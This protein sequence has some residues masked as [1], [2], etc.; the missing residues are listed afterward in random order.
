MIRGYKNFL[1][2]IILENLHPELHDVINKSSTKYSRL[3]KQTELVKKIQDLNARGEKT[4]LEGNMPKGSSRAYLQHAEPHDIEV[5]GKKRKM[6]IG[7]KVAIKADL[8]KHHDD[9]DESLGQMQNRIENSDYH[10]NQHHRILTHVE[11]NKYTDNSE[12]GIFP[13]LVDHD[14]EKHNWSKVAHTS[15]ITKGEFKKR[16]VTDTHPK[17]ISHTEFCDALERAHTRNHGRYWEKT[18]HEEKKLDH[19]ESHP[20]VQKFLDHQNTYDTPPTDYR[21]IKNLGTFE[22]NGTHHIVARDHGYNHETQ[23]AYVEARRKHARQN[24]PY[25]RY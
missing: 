10:L 1:N 12:N 24:D 20:L 15:D 9:P 25:R 21:Q 5:D 7:T 22:H 18:E 14:H 13:P 8:D 11:G 2:S 16:T 17:G 3:K 23:H 4:G 19:V 6:K